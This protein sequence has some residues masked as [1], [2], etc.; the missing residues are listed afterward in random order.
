MSGSPVYR[1]GQLIGAVGYRF[2]SFSKEPIAGI[3]P[4]DMM[5]DTLK[6][7]PQTTQ[8]R[9]PRDRSGAAR[10]RRSRRCDISQTLLRRLR[11]V[12]VAPLRA[13][14]GG[15]FSS[16]AT[17]SHLVNGGAIA[18][19]MAKGD[20]NLFGL[21]TVT[22]VRNDTFIG[23]GHPRPRRLG[24]CE[25]TGC[26][27]DGLNDHRVARERPLRSVASAGSSAP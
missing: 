18:V 11:A 12:T 9:Q 24:R 25:H 15:G 27:G 13:V 20:I 23:F 8:R 14:A 19:V 2:G 17:P 4:I 3:T 7:L 21:G 26:D 5:R 22:E 10:R 6:G 16:G 1:D